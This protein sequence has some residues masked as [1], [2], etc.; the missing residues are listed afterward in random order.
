MSAKDR[1]SVHAHSHFS[2]DEATPAGSLEVD[3]KPWT[4]G[5]SLN[6]RVPWGRWGAYHGP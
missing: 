4:V 6:E 3:R 1:F 5:S 2:L